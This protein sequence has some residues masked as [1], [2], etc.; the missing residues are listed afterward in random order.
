[1]A[2]ASTFDKFSLPVAGTAFSA[3][4][5][6]DLTFQQAIGLNYPLIAPAG[7]VSAHIFSSDIPFTMDTVNVMPNEVVP[8]VDDILPIIQAAREAYN[9]TRVHRSVHVQLTV[10]GMDTDFIYHFSKVC[11]YFSL[12]KRLSYSFRAPFNSWS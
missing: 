4:F 3:A 1:M 8:H 12:P 5:F 10:D 11:T 7:S 2:T 6:R 9:S